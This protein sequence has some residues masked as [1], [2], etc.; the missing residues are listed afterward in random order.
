[1]LCTERRPVFLPLVVYMDSELL[2][3]RH[4]LENKS[5]NT[6]SNQWKRG[7]RQSR[8]VL[9][10]RAVCNCANDGR[11]QRSFP[12]PP[13]SVEEGTKIGIVS[14]QPSSPRSSQAS[15]QLERKRPEAVDLPLPVLATHVSH[16]TRSHPLMIIRQRGTSSL[17]LLLFLI[18]AASSQPDADCHHSIG[19]DEYDFSALKGDH[20]LSRSRSSPPTNMNDTLRFNICNEL[21]PLEGVGSGDQVRIR[22]IPKVPSRMMYAVWQRNVGVS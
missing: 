2:E 18:S 19:D 22:N 14:C 20:V 8:T 11:R 10:S 16:T 4:V 12:P 3:L 7:E 15:V 21:N 17:W 5:P 13:L 1:M 9:P 6:Q